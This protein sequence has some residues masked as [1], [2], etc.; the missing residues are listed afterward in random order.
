MLQISRST[1]QSAVAHSLSQTGL[2]SKN[3]PHKSDNIN[4]HP[5]T[6]LQDA[7]NSITDS[8]EP[9][10][11]KFISF[12]AY[13]MIAL[14]AAVFAVGLFALAFIFVGA[15]IETKSFAAAALG[16]IGLLYL[17]FYLLMVVFSGAMILLVLDMARSFRFL[18]TIA[19]KM[20][21]RND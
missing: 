14:G 20:N 4:T 18:R 17:V 19:R 10:F 12:F 11:F 5:F 9:W 2:F 15:L 6:G 3:C 16:V 8:T 13:L 1:V 21:E 7:E